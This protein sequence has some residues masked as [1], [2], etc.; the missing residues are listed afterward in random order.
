M[1]NNRQNILN[2]SIIGKYDFSGFG[3]KKYSL[4][5]ERYKDMQSIKIKQTT[6]SNSFSRAYFYTEASSKECHEKYMK[7]SVLYIVYRNLAHNNMRCKVYPSNN[8][9]FIKIIS[10]RTILLY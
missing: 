8:L 4:S 7:E 10:K 1:K 6:L 3:E 9:K 5:F 2:Y